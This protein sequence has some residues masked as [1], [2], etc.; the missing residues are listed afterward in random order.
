MISQN[1]KI[2]GFFRGDLLTQEAAQR[3]DSPVVIVSCVGQSFSRDLRSFAQGV[4]MKVNEFD[5]LALF[6]IQAANSSFHVACPFA[7]AH[8]QKL[9]RVGSSDLAD[10]GEFLTLVEVPDVEVPPS[11]EGFKVGELQDPCPHVAAGWVKALLLQMNGEKH[12]LKNILRLCPV[13]KDAEGNGEDRAT[14][15]AEQKR[16]AFGTA[17]ADVAQQFF[18]G[19]GI[20]VF[21]ICHSVGA[22]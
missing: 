13:T 9:G 7:G 6:R 1:H 2:P 22:L 20:E 16:K 14:V 21:V 5:D 8:P 19:S 3:F 11:Q 18:V 15:A 4:A 10:L 12:F 17:L